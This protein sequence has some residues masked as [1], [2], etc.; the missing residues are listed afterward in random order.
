MVPVSTALPAMTLGALPAS[1]R[2]TVITDGSAGSICRLTI[3][4]SEVT[5]ALPT[6]TASIAWWGRAPWPCCPSKQTRKVSVLALTGPSVT[7][8]TPGG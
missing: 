6:S 1:K 3:D 8:R 4:C 2:P 5:N 7:I